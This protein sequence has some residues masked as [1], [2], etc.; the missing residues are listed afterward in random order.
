[1]LHSFFGCG[2]CLARAF[3]W[4]QLV[5]R[6]RAHVPVDEVLE[7][8]NLT[9]DSFYSSQGRIDPAFDDHNDTL[10]DDLAA[11]HP[12]AVSLEMETFQLFHLAQLCRPAGAIRAAAAGR[13]PVVCAGPHTR[14]PDAHHA[15]AYA[16]G[17][18]GCR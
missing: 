3:S 9:A 12:K 7:G 17:G 4:A 14:V 6:M 15:V 1:M 10:L 5:D 2:R 8:V 18:H 13:P 16:R 11:A